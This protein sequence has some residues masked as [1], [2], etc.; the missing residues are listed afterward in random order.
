[1]G[2]FLGR[3]DHNVSSSLAAAWSGKLQAPSK[4]LVWFE[5]SAHEVAVKEP[6]K[7]LMS[8]AHVRPLAERGAT[9]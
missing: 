5:N 4:R 7:T 9:H 3:H 2:L 1:M 6:G 8:L